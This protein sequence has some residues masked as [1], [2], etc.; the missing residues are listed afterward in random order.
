MRG[1]EGGRE[2]G[3]EGGR[4]GEREEGREGREGG[5]RGGEGGRGKVQTGLNLWC[6]FLTS[7]KELVRLTVTLTPRTPGAEIH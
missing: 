1:R 2:G 4:K 6:S 5:R 7:Y 3:G